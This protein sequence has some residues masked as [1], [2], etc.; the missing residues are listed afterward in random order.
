MLIVV[1]FLLIVFSMLFVAFGYSIF[2]NKHYNLA[3]KFSPKLND[4][5]KVTFAKRMGLIQ[6]V[7]GIVLWACSIGS[8]WLGKVGSIVIIC[9]SLSAFI[10]ALA[11][12]TIYFGVR[13]KKLGNKLSN[14]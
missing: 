7:G 6:F 5:L 2:F 8:L 12:H 1:K 4:A 3:L 10:I 14:N 9:V 11:S 13:N